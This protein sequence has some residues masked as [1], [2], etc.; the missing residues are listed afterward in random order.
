MHLVQLESLSRGI[1]GLLL[2]CL[3]GFYTFSFPTPSSPYPSLPLILLS[4]LLSMSPMN[5]SCSLP[6]NT[7][8]DMDVFRYALLSLTCSQ[9]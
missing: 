9:K 6:P 4:P 2:P 3:G 7:P 1:P 8:R 5:S